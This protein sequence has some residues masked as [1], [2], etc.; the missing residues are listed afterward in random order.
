MRWK[1]LPIPHKLILD[2]V[3][4]V[5][6]SEGLPV[7]SSSEPLRQDYGTDLVVSLLAAQ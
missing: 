3:I 6:T 7:Q 5:R 1:R 4:R 2:E